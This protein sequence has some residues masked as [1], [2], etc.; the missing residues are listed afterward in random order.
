M[1]GEAQAG[2]PRSFCFVF[3]IRV[4]DGAAPA[5]GRGALM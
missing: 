3:L 4:G 1:A 2:S 5:A